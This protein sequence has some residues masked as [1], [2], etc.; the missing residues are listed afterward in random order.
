MKTGLLILLA[1]LLGAFLA[2]FLLEDSGYVLINMRGYAVEMSVPGLV[3]ALALLYLAIRIIVR[4]WKAP[5]QLGQAAGHYR[6]N[7]ARDRLTKG[8]IAVAEGDAAR[9]ERLLARSAGNSGAPL[10]NYL[11]AAKAAQTLGS[12]QRRDNWLKL[13]LERRP[14]AAPAILV[15]QA[16]YQME[17]GKYEEALGTLARLEAQTPGN[18]RGLALTAEAYRKLQRWQ[19]LESLL[20]KLSR[21]KTLEPQEVAA[22]LED[23]ASAL[24]ANA[25]GEKDSQ[26][27]EKLWQTLPK[28]LRTRPSLITAYTRAAAS[29]GD[30]DKLEKTIR[31]FLKTAWIPALVDTYG[32]L[33][34][35]N[36][37]AHLSHAEAWLTR[38]GEDPVL[39][40]SAARLCIQ[41]QLWGKARSYLETS[42]G[43]HP[44]PVGYRL[45][46]QLLQTMGEEDGAAEAFRLGLETATAAA[47]LPALE[48]PDTDRR[49]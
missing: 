23:S 37:R 38:R 6:E 21:A 48:A 7:R 17:R 18:G 2:H 29:C 16:E 42:L 8:L 46:G 12:E 33:E 45:Y 19:D 27:V 1:L 32:V 4:L 49:T 44:D 39:L 28:A 31:K 26:R 5:R 34:T 3:L 15:T 30:H 9:G 36:P 40:L 22:L 24:F 35:S 11:T 20:P 43:M 14:D 25:A 13:A 47:R 10:V 41:N